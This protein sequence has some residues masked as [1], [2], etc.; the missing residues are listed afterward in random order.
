[1]CKRHSAMWR[2][3]EIYTNTI[4]DSRYLYG[5]EKSTKYGQYLMVIA[6]KLRVYVIY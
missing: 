1:M 3:F 5:E 4:P 6:G 2:S